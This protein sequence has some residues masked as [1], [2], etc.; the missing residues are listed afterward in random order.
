MVVDE[1]LVIGAK[2]GRHGLRIVVLVLLLLFPP[3]MLFVEKAAV[4]LRYLWW[5]VLL[6]ALAVWLI[7]GPGRAKK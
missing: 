1:M 2:H 5:L 6:L 7:W 3:V 4:E